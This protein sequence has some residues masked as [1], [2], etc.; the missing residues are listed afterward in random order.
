MGASGYVYLPPPPK[1]S[2]RRTSPRANLTPHPQRRAAESLWFFNVLGFLQAWKF[3]AHTWTYMPNVETGCR[4]Q[5]TLKL[6]EQSV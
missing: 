6:P 4:F 3:P 1:K 5:M 2:L